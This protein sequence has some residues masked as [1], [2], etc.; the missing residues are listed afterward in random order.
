MNSSNDSVL[1]ELNEQLNE[2]AKIRE[3]LM[4]LVNHLSINTSDDVKFQSSILATLT[5][6]TNQLT[7]K[8]SVDS[9]II[10]VYSIISVEFG[11]IEMLSTVEW[12][13]VDGYKSVV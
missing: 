9:K 3:S 1:R 7:R 6:A 8:T 10:F 4:M 2:H 5:A 11:I 13:E 12:F